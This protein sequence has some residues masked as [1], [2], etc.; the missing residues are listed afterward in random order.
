MYREAL[1]GDLKLAFITYQH[2]LENPMLTPDYEQIAR[3]RYRTDAT[4]HSRVDSLVYGVMR[5]I[6]KHLDESQQG[7][8]CR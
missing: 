5:V 4:F 7:Q 6:D 3:G 2:T 8:Q 1:F